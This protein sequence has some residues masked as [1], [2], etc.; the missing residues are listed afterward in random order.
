MNTCLLAFKADYSIDSIILIITGLILFATAWIMKR[1][2][3]DNAKLNSKQ[4]AENTIIKQMEFHNNILNRINITAQ[5]AQTLHGQDAFVIFYS[6][7]RAHYNSMPGNFENNIKGEEKRI[8]DS[9]TQLYNEHGSQFGNYFKKL[10]LLVSYINDIKI[11][12][13]DKRYYIDLVKSQ[14]SKYEILLLAYDCIWIQDKEK[15]RNFIE[16]AQKYDLL[17]ALET[18]ELII[19]KGSI[20]HE[21]IFNERYKIFFNNPLQFTN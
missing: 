20:K 7:L 4:V 1:G 5:T 14:L 12:G 2:N 8:S 18:N 15:G 11:K 19:S 21:V 3:D 9:F 10:Y 6:L 16:F 13:F 17:S